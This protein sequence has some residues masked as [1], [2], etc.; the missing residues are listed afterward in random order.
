MVKKPE[1]ASLSVQIKNGKTAALPGGVHTP[2]FTEI[3]LKQDK[4]MRD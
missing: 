3:K 1:K 4:T 2:D